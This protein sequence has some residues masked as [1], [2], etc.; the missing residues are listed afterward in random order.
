LFWNGQIINAKRKFHARCVTPGAIA[1]QP[2]QESFQ[3]LTA[4]RHNGAIFTGRWA[5]PD[6]ALVLS[7]QVKTGS[8]NSATPF[9]EASF[10]QFSGRIHQINNPFEI[11]HRR[12]ISN[13]TVF[14][15]QSQGHWNPVQIKGRTP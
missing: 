6:G 15:F 10:R 11:V 4:V 13:L 8:G 1:W 2:H 5:V 3:N 12:M 14:K 9:P 7:R